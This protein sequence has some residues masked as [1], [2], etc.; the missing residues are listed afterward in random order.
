MVGRLIQLI[1]PAIACVA[2]CT[3]AGATISGARAVR[4][5]RGQVIGVWIDPIRRPHGAEALVDRALRT[6]TDAAAGRFALQM[7]P[8]RDASIRFHFTPTGDGLYGGTAP[9][10]DP[11]SGVMLRADIMVT[12]APDLDALGRS[13]VIYLTSLHELGHALGLDH[14]EDAATIMYR[15]KEPEDAPR[16]FA[17]YRTRIRSVE[18]IGTAGATGLSS[19]DIA[20]LAA[21]YD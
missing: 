17:E 13:I 7:T 16:Y 11:R 15:F 20:A 9:V 3:V 1:K 2:L 18:D 8:A 21:L 10:V 14:T 4:W 6:W 5:Q 12:T 19:A